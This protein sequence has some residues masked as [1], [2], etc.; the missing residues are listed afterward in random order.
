MKENLK[1]TDYS[2]PDFYHF[3]ESTVTLAN[4]AAEQVQE[5]QNLKVLDIGAG[6]GVLGL[7]FARKH[8]SVKSLHWVEPQTVF[9][10]SLKKNDRGR[11]ELVKGTKHLDDFY[12]ESYDIIL[13]NPPFYLL[14][15]GRT[16]D[17]KSREQCHF[18]DISDEEAVKNYILAP[19]RFSKGA[20]ILGR[21]EVFQG[22]KKYLNQN[23]WITRLYP[24]E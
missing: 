21:R 3:S 8:G 7:E 11:D 2:Q 22:E 24:S 17:N 18:W 4:Y 15:S 16:P 13:M 20:F 19:K 10:H 1:I 23:E 6:C 5:Y 12:N 14:G 9:H